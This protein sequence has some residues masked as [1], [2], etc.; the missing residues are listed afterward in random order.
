MFEIPFRILKK[1]NTQKINVNSEENFIFNVQ[2]AATSMQVNQGN[3]SL[4]ATRKNT[5]STKDLISLT[6]NT[7]L[8]MNVTIDT[9]PKDFSLLQENTKFEID[10]NPNIMDKEL[11]DNIENSPSSVNKNFPSD[12]DPI[13]Q[14]DDG[15]NNP[16]DNKTIQRNGELFPP[17][18]VSQILSNLNILNKNRNYFGKNK[19]YL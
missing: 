11:V 5:N 4:R 13:L 16:I 7:L 8:E 10:P 18:N 1:S 9:L 17:I 6:N 19:Y 3:I 12:K 14:L 2:S 15:N